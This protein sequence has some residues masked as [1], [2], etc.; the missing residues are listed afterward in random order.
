[1]SFICCQHTKGYVISKLMANDEF[2]K[3]KGFV[4]NKLKIKIGLFK[5]NSNLEL[6]TGERLDN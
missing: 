4:G 3:I 1:M 6:F 2:Y 5:N